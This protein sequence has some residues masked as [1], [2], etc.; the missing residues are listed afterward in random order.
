[1]AALICAIRVLPGVTMLR[2]T[3]FAL[4]L[5][6]AVARA[7]ENK[8]FD[9]AAAFG[10]RPSATGM[11]LSPDGQS[12]AFIRPDAGPGTIL[13]TID[14]SK[15]DDSRVALYTNGK[16]DRLSDCHWVSDQR[17]VCTL[18]RNVKDRALLIPVSRWI[19]VDREGG[20]FRMLSNDD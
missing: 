7:E 8:P 3:V 1:M 19:A 13:T 14:L 2:T 15:T 9:A 10:A 12:V 11:S 20:N 6:A 18:L 17:L 5:M 4:L 16:P